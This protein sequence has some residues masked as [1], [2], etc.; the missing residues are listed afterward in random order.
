MKSSRM[1]TYILIAM[2][3]GIAVGA[4]IHGYY[5]NPATQKVFATA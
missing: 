4:G 3:L 1:T 5:A 2:L